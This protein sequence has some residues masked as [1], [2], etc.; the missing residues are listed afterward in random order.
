MGDPGSIGREPSPIKPTESSGVGQVPG[1]PSGGNI[2]N[3]LHTPVS[4]LGQ[5]KKVL[6]DT[7][8]EKEGTKM[9]NSFIKSFAMQMISQI[10]Q[11]AEQAKKAA[12]Q[13]R[14]GPQG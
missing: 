6:I 5:L 2:E 14:Q 8:G 13:M 3:A 10:Q 9:Y 12:Q 4:T 11:S 1:E 7:L